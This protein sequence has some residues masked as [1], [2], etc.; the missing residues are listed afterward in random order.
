MITIHTDRDR[1][2]Y[3]IQHFVVDTEENLVVFKKQNSIKPGSTIFV[4]DTSKYYMLNSLK[5]WIEINPY[6]KN[7]SN[8][9]SGDND[10]ENPE[11]ND[12]IYDGGSIDGSDPV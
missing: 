9:G 11:Q 10:G 12:N 5:Q 6:G 4:I 7:S 2:S 8:N 1:I 3:G